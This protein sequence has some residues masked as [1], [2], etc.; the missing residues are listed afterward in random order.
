MIDLDSQGE[1]VMPDYEAADKA[2][3]NLLLLV[4]EKVGEEA[5][6]TAREIEE[7]IVDTEGLSRFPLGSQE[8]HL[9]IGGNAGTR[10][11]ARIVRSRLQG[12][13]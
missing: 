11:A 8:M 1:C 5:E 2:L 10:R 13:K 6:A 3:D 12:M 7:I 9:T 4:V